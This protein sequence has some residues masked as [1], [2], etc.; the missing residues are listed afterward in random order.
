MGRDEIGDELK[1]LGETIA[2]LLD[3]LR[4][5]ERVMAIIKADLAEVKEEFATPRRSEF[6]EHD[7]EV[8]DELVVVL[9]GEEVVH[10]GVHA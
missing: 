10:V 5:R 6:I 7:G 2:D 3:I 9:R 1:Q 8:D 4:S